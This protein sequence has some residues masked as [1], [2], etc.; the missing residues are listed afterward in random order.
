[1]QFLAVEGVREGTMWNIITD[2]DQETLERR[3]CRVVLIKMDQ[4]I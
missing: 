3:V 2:G 1:M 4:E